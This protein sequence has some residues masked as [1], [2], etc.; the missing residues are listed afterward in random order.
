MTGSKKLLSVPLPFPDETF[1]SWIAR[2]HILSGDPSPTRTVT[3]LFGTP[4]FG[5]TSNL[6]CHLEHFFK[7]LPEGLMA[8]VDEMI[9]QLTLLPYYR[10]FLKPSALAGIK[11]AM[12]FGGRGGVATKVSFARNTIL[13]TWFARFC[14]VCIQE[15]LRRFGQPYWHRSHQLPGVTVCARHGCL[16]LERCRSCQHEIGQYNHLYLP[17]LVCI[18][19]HRLTEQVDYVARDDRRLL[20][21]S[22]S[23]AL[24]QS[25]M[26]PI[27]LEN[28]RRAYLVG[29]IGKGLA[30]SSKKILQKNF[31]ETFEA[32]YGAGFLATLGLPLQKS[33]CNDWLAHM[34]TAVRSPHPVKHL[35]VIGFLFG[36]W[37]NFIDAMNL[38]HVDTP[39]KQYPPRQ[40]PDD[41]WIERLRELL[42]HQGRTLKETAAVLGK[43][44]YVLSVI[45]ERLGIR[46]RLKKPAGGKDRSGQILQEMLSTEPLEQ[47]AV[48]H[49][50]SVK[51]LR[52]L[53]YEAGPRFQQRRNRILKNARR[54]AYR[55][56]IDTFLK[57]KSGIT[58]LD[59]RTAAYKELVWLKN[60]DRAWLDRKLKAH[61]VT[62][63]RRVLR[64]GRFDWVQKDKS[65]AAAL[66][67]A[68]ARLMNAP[69]RP[70]RVGIEALRRALGKPGVL[71]GLSKLPVTAAQLSELVEQKEDYHRR[72]IRW[73]FDDMTE[74]GLRLTRGSILAHVHL[75]VKDVS[76]AIIELIEQLVNK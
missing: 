15:D 40:R 57:G 60:H 27:P 22:I 45:A 4:A 5:V 29:L 70:K 30:V 25:T 61:K 34:R 48:R 47:I 1:P 6:P 19:G 41:E 51:H 49:G 9:D 28:I 2:Y 24:L 74:K 7:Q 36:S 42:I 33:Y 43:S 31:H 59:I 17:H 23:D 3:R 58:N 21:A 20:L 68:A 75:K 32:F 65:M 14:P 55:Q 10:P 44:D 13:K 67:S 39:R 64:N 76:A 12:A 50:I 37:E 56:C 63:G 52:K 16:L 53:I 66:E 8:G 26:G 71:H 73:A 62:T 54:D 35:L 69:G 11:D 46:K 38:V 72:V 18:N